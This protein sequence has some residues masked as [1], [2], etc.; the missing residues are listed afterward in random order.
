MK[1]N[2]TLFI[3]VTVPNQV[4]ERSCCVLKGIHSVCLYDFSSIYISIVPTV[5]YSCF[6]VYCDVCHDYFH[7]E[8]VVVVVIV[9]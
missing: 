3:E 2:Q 1:R 5:W 7:S 4:S 8:G 9:W 6:S